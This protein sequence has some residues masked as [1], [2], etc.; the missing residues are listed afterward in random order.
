MHHAWE[1]WEMLT[2]FWQESLKGRC[3]SERPKRRWEDNIGMDLRETG[4]KVWTGYIRLRIGTCG[5]LL[6]IRYWTSGAPLKAGNFSIS[7]VA[8]GFSR[9]THLSPCS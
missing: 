6:W 8:V 9:R 5:G 3:H 7:W 4:W 2:K 1:R